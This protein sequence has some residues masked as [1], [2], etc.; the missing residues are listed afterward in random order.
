MNRR[1]FVKSVSAAAV[2]SQLPF[3]SY[4][5]D[6]S[7]EIEIVKPKR[8]SIGSTIGLISPAGFI[9]EKQL[10]ESV[11]NLEGLGFKVVYSDKILSRYG[12]L[13]GEDEIRAEEVNL[14][15]KRDDVDGIFCTRGGYGCAR[16]L[17]ML[18]YE[19]I[20]KNP[21]VLIGYS[22]IT[23]LLYAIFSQTG[24]VCFHGP[25]GI[26]TFNDYSV[27]YFKRTL[28]NPEK[29]LTIKKAIEENIDDEYTS[30]PIITGKAEGKLVGGNLS[31]VASMVGTKYDIPSEGKIIFLEEIGEEPYRVDR[32]LMQMKLA[33]KFDGAK[34]IAMGVFKNSRSKKNDEEP[35]TSF[36]LKEVL[37]DILGSLKIPI[38]YGLSFGHISNKFTLPVGISAEL[39]TLNQTVTFLEPAVI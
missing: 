4:S 5:A 34:G 29:T 2:L 12:Y 22:D 7:N 13:G 39:D 35:I 21:K 27:E 19:S 36:T 15:F 23:S 16:I 24:L 8:L 32:M 10:E 18:D 6:F 38:I 26:S 14:M 20:R 1:K 28:M 3:K 17:S 11:N 25:V 30:Y 33:G 37:F 31:I 9:S